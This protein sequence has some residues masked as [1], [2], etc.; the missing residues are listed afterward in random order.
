MYVRADQ[1]GA[2]HGSLLVG[3]APSGAVTCEAPG[4]GAHGVSGVGRGEV[5]PRP[6]GVLDQQ[7]V[8]PLGVLAHAAHLPR[9]GAL[10]AVQL[11]HRTA[12]PTGTKGWRA[13]ICAALDGGNAGIPNPRL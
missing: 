6:L 12:L 2:A 13:R 1:R 5:A 10:R 8:L 11:Q 9:P 3:I 4:R 7:V